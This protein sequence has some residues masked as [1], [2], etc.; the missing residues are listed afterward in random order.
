[1][2]LNRRKEAKSLV[3]T[4]KFGRFGAGF[5]ARA[6]G[7]S[8]RAPFG[9]RQRRAAPYSGRFNLA[10]SPEIDDRTVQERTC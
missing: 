1:M 2:F 8:T 6:C 9:G 4:K 3:F 7:A 10:S 5:E